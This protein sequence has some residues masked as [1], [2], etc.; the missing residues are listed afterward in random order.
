MFSKSFDKKIIY[1][2]SQE[3]EAENMHLK[4]F[5]RDHKRKNK[6]INSQLKHKINAK[7]LFRGNSQNNSV[8]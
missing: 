6:T 1:N 3:I 8:V 7:L 5:E 2:H 4:L